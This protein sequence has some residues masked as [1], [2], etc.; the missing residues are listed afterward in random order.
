MAG[1]KKEFEA[2]LNPSRYALQDLFYATLR[3]DTLALTSFNFE[4]SCQK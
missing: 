3:F 1:P 2:D 4:I